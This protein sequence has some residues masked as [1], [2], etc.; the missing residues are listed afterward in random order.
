MSIIYRFQ[1]W[2]RATL[3]VLSCAI[4]PAAL[5]LDP[6]VALDGYRHERWGE[7][8]GAPRYVDAL[9]RSEDGWLW[10]GSR[11]AG[12]LRFDGLRFLPFES[13]D[14][15]RPQNN[16]I[17][18]LRPGPGGDLWIGHGNGGLSVLRKG[19]YHH[20]LTP[21]QSGSVF[22]ISLGADGAPWVAS[23]R[24]LFRVEG[25]RVVRVGPEQ[26][27]GGARA[28]YVLSDGAGRVWATDGAAL[29]LREAGAQRFRL[30]RQVRGDAMLLEAQDGGVWLVLGKQ[31]ERVAPPA[32][33]R[34]PVQPGSANTYQSLFDRDG[35]VWSGNCP[36]GVCVLRPAERQHS[37]RFT[38]V[39]AA[40]RLD[41]PWQMTSLSVLSLMEDRDGS[42][43][44]GTPSGLERLRDHV[45]HMVPQLLDRGTSHPARHPDGGIVAARVQRLDDTAGLVRIENGKVSELPDPIATRVLDRA[46]DGTLV[47]GGQHGVERHGPAGIEHIPL[48]PAVSAAADTVRP[49]RLSAGNDEIWLWT[50]RMGAWHYRDGGWTRPPVREDQPHEVAFDAA[51]RSYLG[52]N[53]NRLRIVDGDAVRE[54]DAQDGLDVGKFSLIFP[55][56]P[57]LVSGED[58]MQILEGSRFRRLAVAAPDGIGAASGIVTDA[59]GVRWINAERGIYRVT[60]E[61]WTRSMNDP[62]VPLRGRLFDAADGYLGGG[63]SRMLSR[64]AAIAGDGTLW[65]A[66]ERGLAWIDPRKTAP[67]PATPAAEVIGLSSGG[68]H[69]AVGMDMAL[70]QGTENVQIDYTAPSLRMP[71]KVSFR[72]RLAGSQEWEDAGTRRSAFFQ[73]LR[74]GAHTF[75]V[76]AINESGVPG[77]VTSLA[78]HIPPHW[79]Q[80]WWFLAAC[81]LAV[82]LLA[83]WVYRRR[84]RRLAERI[85]GELMARMRERES[86]ARALHDTFLQGVQGMLLRMHSVLTGL[87][88]D[89]P[90]RAEFERVLEN[91][92]R[93]LEEGRDEVQGLRQGFANADAFWQGLLRDV[94]LILPGG[95]QRLELAAAPGAV[96]RLPVRLRRDVHAI[97]REALLNALRHTPGAVRLSAE[98]A[99]R[100]LALTVSDDG[101]GG[102]ASDKPGH[103]G[104]QGMRERAL[105]IGARLRIDSGPAGT[106]V[107]LA[108]ALGPGQ[109]DQASW[110]APPSRP[111]TRTASSTTGTIASTHRKAASGTVDR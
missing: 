62:G 64:T 97:V 89:S 94:D 3:L 13:I 41:Q 99:Q 2:L 5:A 108:I 40:E 36:L 46:P 7:L 45:V 23:W 30:V 50:G 10:V 24:G 65:L 82:L 16:N 39:G 110:P 55:G 26:G 84:T 91:A 9:A 100:G 21:E 90:A 86:I 98:M 102:C 38:P 71:Q 6:T 15:S 57:L 59:A 105:Q 92:E 70:D 104:L 78:F 17:S 34:I 88:S 14:G 4:S 79:F 73:R 32:P 58:G 60:L 83:A 51:G 95:S 68:R 93:V 69:Y 42:I 107:T 47:Y 11:Y 106:R 20:L 87:P 63:V 18:A 66:G 96:E 76:M 101:A 44:V 25:G 56:T 85:E 19:R 29:Y 33:R 53:G 8:E 37:E 1:A 77:P 72:Y 49:R 74:P 103:F 61:D 27:Y 35:N 31:F 109:A 52:L 28:E 12:L 80:T 111:S 22:A 67:N 48:P 43:W 54:Y 81:V 75:E